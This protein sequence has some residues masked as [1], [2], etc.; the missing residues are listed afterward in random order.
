MEQSM[1]I[2]QLKRQVFPQPINGFHTTAYSHS[3][4]QSLLFVV[5]HKCNKRN[6]QIAT[7]CRHGLRGRDCA[8]A[9]CHNWLE[10]NAPRV[11]AWNL[12]LAR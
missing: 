9:A 11:Y 5:L 6:V 4:V 3:S 7:G 2:D 12:Q 1:N 10:R 8:C